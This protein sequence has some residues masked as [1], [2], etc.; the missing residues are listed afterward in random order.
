VTKSSR[1]LGSLAVGV[2]GRRARPVTGPS[3]KNGKRS[4]LERR[5]APQTKQR[6]G[7]NSEERLNHRHSPF[8]AQAD[9]VGGTMSV[10]AMRDWSRAPGLVAGIGGT[11]FLIKWSVP[12]TLALR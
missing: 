10:K 7:P 4:S 5:R 8:I 9:V 3:W 12:A 11:A 1:E 6:R 2:P